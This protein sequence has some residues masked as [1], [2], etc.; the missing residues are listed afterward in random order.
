MDKLNPHISVDCVV[1]A[2]DYSQLKVLLIEIEKVQEV[3]AMRHKLKLPGSLIY[4]REDFDLSAR[5]ILYELTGL[6][7]IYMQQFGVFSNPERLNPPEDLEWA[8]IINQ[9][10]SL[11]RVVTIAYFALIQLKDVNRTAQT[12]WYPVD[13]LP[14]LI[15]D[16]NL[17]I[18]RSLCHLREE[19]RTKSLCFEL[20]P[21]KFTIRQV[22]EIYRT[23]L[24]INIDKS[25]FR[26]KL[27]HFTFLVP[28]KEKEKCVSH[29]PAQ[30]YR[31]D[32]RLYEKYEKG[33]KEIIF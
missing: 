4:E 8:R 26:R 10:Q 17:I 16:H 30:L 13:E 3:N 27:K 11:S 1:F 19:M 33:R 21:K 12:I 2:Y 18:R 20:L 9:N 28:L 6:Q 14:D 22:F 24:G 15:F 25:N 32:R 29:K 7:N 23:I 31:F 5:R